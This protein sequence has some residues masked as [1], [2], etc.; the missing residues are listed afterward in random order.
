MGFETHS[1]LFIEE[2]LDLLRDVEAP[3]LELEENPERTDLVDTIFRAM[4]TIKGSS[5]MFGFD[6]IAHFTHDIETT[7]DAIR[8]GT[9]K[10]TPEI[11][12]LTLKAKDCIREL[13]YKNNS[14]S[15]IAERENILS[16]L[17][18]I[19]GSKQEIT[20]SSPPE[21]PVEEHETDEKAL[22]HITFI[23]DKE[24]L[25]R[26]VQ[27]APLMAELATLGEIS[28]AANISELP[29]V[30]SFDPEIC[31]LSW[32]IDIISDRPLRDIRSVFIFVEDYAKIEIQKKDMNQL[33]EKFPVADE[34]LKTAKTPV[35]NGKTLPAKPLVERRRTDSTSIRVKNEK[36]DTLV[37]LVG[38]MV[39][40]HAR[41]VQESGK[42]EIGEFLVISEVLGRLTA[43]LRDITMSVRMVPLADTFASFNRLVHDLSK[44]LGKKIK[45]ETEGGETELDKNVIEELRD[46]LMHIIRN[47][48]DHGIEL[49]DVRTAK[50]KSDT[51]TI[52]LL[53]EHTGANVRISISDDGAGLDRAKILAKAIENGMAVNPDADDRTIYSLIFE[54]GFSTAAQATDVSGRGVGMDVVKKNME[55]LRGKVD[56]ATVPGQSATISLTI[57]LT[58]AII[59]GFMTQVCGRFYIFNLSLVRECLAYDG[60]AEGSDIQGMI[61]IR[62]N[63]IPFINLRGAFG[64]IGEKCLFPQIVITEYEGNEIGFLVDRV[65]G[66]H[67]TVIKPLG[68]GV[69][70]AEMFSGASILGDGS[71]ALILDLNKIVSKA[72]LSDHTKTHVSH[73]NSM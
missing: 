60:N 5:G 30:D 73:E 46:P 27:I 14:E 16:R 66:H 52:R 40:L 54:P 31:Y 13:L 71:I 56:V 7:F 65:I 1:E 59:D 23:P 37:N 70:N 3:L 62:E 64:V 22:Y 55:K 9:L 12:E 63:Y 61:R 25:L 68:R 24:I 29:F 48:A 41:L 53:A 34:I 47:S 44:S 21:L 20:A 43:D 45:I 38:E 51:G 67:Q 15:Q 35:S 8:K 36:L 2:A 17:G 32:E 10:V 26:G 18:A 69:R 72:E 11:I 39:T 42:A 50:G 33:E 49:P 19:S 57:P 4:H 58:L 6:D 28:V